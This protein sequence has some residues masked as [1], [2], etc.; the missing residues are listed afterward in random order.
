MKLKLM[1]GLALFL[2]LAL[3]ATAQLS[4]PYAANAKGTYT[5]ALANVKSYTVLYSPAGNQ[6]GFCNGPQPPWGYSCATDLGQE[7]I[8]GTM[9][10]DGAG[11]VESTSTYND[12]AD[13]NAYTCSS[14]RNAYE[15]CPALV[16]SGHPYAAETFAPG[17]TIDYDGKTFQTPAGGNLPAPVLYPTSQPSNNKLPE[18]ANAC[19]NSPWTPG[20]SPNCQWVLLYGSYAGNNDSEK[21]N[22]AGTYTVSQGGLG[23]LTICPAESCPADASPGK[24]MDIIMMVPPI[25]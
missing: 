3:N 21:G 16:P 14:H 25:G 11:H 5:F 4:S 22:A 20:G 19:P 8:T 10:L 1:L 15:T 17:A 6:A 24:T 2:A 18:G 12:V 7:V 13:P 9:V 23:M